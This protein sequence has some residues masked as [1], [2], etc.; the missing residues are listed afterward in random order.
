M[1]QNEINLYV[2]PEET[3]IARCS[4]DAQGEP[5]VFNLPYV[6]LSE[7]FREINRFLWESRH[8]LTRFC[9]N[10]EGNVIVDVTAWNQASVNEYFDAFLYFLKDREESLHCTF[11]SEVDFSDAV[12]DRISRLFPTKTVRFD[13]GS[14]RKPAARIGFAVDER[15]ERNNA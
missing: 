6:P 8:Q 5:F 2:G 3:C 9:N 4:A 12:C 7:H 10:Y 1:R 15:E 13:S 14:G 11:I